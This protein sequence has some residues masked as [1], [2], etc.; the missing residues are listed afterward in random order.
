MI[1][2]KGDLFRDESGGVWLMGRGRICMIGELEDLILDAQ[3]IRKI[4]VEEKTK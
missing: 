4:R 1:Y 3:A 2:K